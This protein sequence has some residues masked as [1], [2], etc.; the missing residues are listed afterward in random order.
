[1]LF[2]TNI[3][4]QIYLFLHDYGVFLSSYKSPC[5]KNLDDFKFDTLPDRV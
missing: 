2:T 4:Y 3:F 1:M 5:S